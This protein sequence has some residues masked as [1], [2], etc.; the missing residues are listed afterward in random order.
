VI[1]SRVGGLPELVVDGTTGF[2]VK[3]GDVEGLAN[4]IAKLAGDRVRIREMGQ[5]GKERLNKDFTLERMARE[6]EEYYYNL[7]DCMRPPATAPL[8]SPPA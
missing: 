3:P 6:N 5:K 1:A 2:L 7:L 4:A 8:C